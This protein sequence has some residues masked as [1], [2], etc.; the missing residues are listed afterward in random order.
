M[1][2]ATPTTK[3]AVNAPIVL[4]ECPCPGLQARVALDLACR[5]DPA[6]RSA[7]MER[8]ARDPEWFIDWFLDTFDSRDK[9][10]F[11]T[12]S[13]KDKPFLL[14]PYQRDL[15]RQLVEHQALPSDL[16][17]E[18]SR[19]MGVTWLV[20]AWIFHQWMFSDG[21]MALLGSFREP[22]V[23]DRTVDSLFGKL[24][25]ML[26]RLPGW[27]VPHRF[28]WRVHR[29]KLI[30][31]HPSKPGN[32]IL[33]NTATEGFARSGRYT[34]I[35]FDEGSE[36]AELDDAWTA[37]SRS[38]ECRIITGTPKGQNQ[39]YDLRETGL[40]DITRIHWSLHP[41]RDEE[42]YETQ[43]KRMTAEQ[44]AQELDISYER[45][46]SGVIYPAWQECLFG[47]YPYQKGWPLWISLDFGY[48][49]S[50]AITVWQRNP[51]TG[52]YRVIDC[53]E[54]SG[55]TIDYY[56]P[57]LT[58]QYD[59]KIPHHY[60]ERAREWIARRA[61]WGPAI[62]FGDP[63]GKISNQVTGTSVLDVLAEQFGVFVTVNDSARDYHTRRTLTELG[64]RGLE[65]NL[66]ECGK[67]DR[68][69]RNARYRDK[70]STPLHDAY[71][72]LRSAVEYFFVNVPSPSA[73]S[74]RPRVSFEVADWENL[75]RR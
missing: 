3:G 71:S 17:I 26:Q 75:H 18:K 67:L 48:R 9:M 65:V 44:I 64:L 49:D 60:D 34:V 58:G 28:S 32:V 39:F 15:L 31:Q 27:M 41:E 52:V 1:T 56:V 24:D 70:S 23:D 46:A 42:W 10:A 68:A 69:M 2:I 66:P 16:F 5:A 73:I 14:L 53:Y 20:L 11:V 57:F 55:K 63:A 12:T 38:T 29:K 74:D 7:V 47:V 8:A 43:K 37:A 40:I 22:E 21:F 54:H 45:S 62:I 13:T 50:T 30:L 33:G 61:A 25:Y 6:I 51:E 36:W 59:A 4:P 72:H 19:D 35:F